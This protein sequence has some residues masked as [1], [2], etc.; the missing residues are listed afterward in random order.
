MVDILHR[1]GIQGG[2]PEAVYDALAT[3]DGLAAWW[4]EDTTGDGAAGGRLAFRFAAGGFDMEVL[5]TEPGH[6][7]V[8]EV[9]EGPAEW[10]GTQVVWELRQE[11]EFTIVLFRHQGWREP[12]EFMH[13][14]STKWAS[15]LLS[16]KALLETGTGAPA[17]YDVRI[18][19]V[20]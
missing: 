13:H 15:Y 3:R 17:P 4:T 12:V 16:L 8:W 1:I 5:R 6:S 19:E 9:V 10:V 20:D 11:G 18:G 7:V 2:T 14:C